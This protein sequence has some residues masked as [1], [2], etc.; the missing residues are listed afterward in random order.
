MNI[1]SMLFRI[2]YSDKNIPK[3]YSENIFRQIKSFRENNQC[4]INQIVRVGRYSVIS[5]MGRGGVVLC[6]G[7]PMRFSILAVVIDRTSYILFIIR[8]IKGS[9]I[10][11]QVEVPLYSSFS[12]FGQINSITILESALNVSLLDETSQSAPMCIQCDVQIS[13]SNVTIIAS[14]QNLSG[15]IIQSISSISIR[16][17]FFQLRLDV[18][19][20]SGI[21]CI[22]CIQV[23]V[24]NEEMKAF[25]IDNINLIDN[26]TTFYQ[27]KFQFWS[28]YFRSFSECNCR[29]V[30]ISVLQSH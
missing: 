24:V 9:I 15:L 21:G 23:L 8:L 4:K 27:S 6:G 3:T 12:L 1:Q 29:H 30:L 25:L 19:L 28:H 14:E 17:C 18:N 7:A 5:V 11:M 2:R 10:S 16:N 20:I 22:G 13:Y 26:I